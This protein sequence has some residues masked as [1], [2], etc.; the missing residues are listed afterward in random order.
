MIGELISAVGKYFGGEADRRSQ[1][2]IN[3]QM[4]ADKEQDRALQR[5]FAQHG[6]RWRV[7]DA[8]AAGLHPIYALGGS[9]ATYTPSAISLGSSKSALGEM[10]QDIGRAINSTRTSGEREDAFMQAMKVNTLRKSE[11]EN[12]LL[13]AQVAKLRASTNPPMP[14]GVTPGPVPEAK[15][16]EDR[17][18]LRIGGDEIH[19]DPRSTNAE[20]FEKRYGEL[21][22]FV[23]G[24]ALLW[25]DYVNTMGGA[26]ERAAANEYHRPRRGFSYLWD[27]FLHRKYREGR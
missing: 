23:Y 21:S 3:R 17:P 10:G 4:L 26:Q 24:P 5:E 22:D 9:G 11:L 18:R 15:K 12:D 7:E 16:F 20:D 14:T 19:T 13:S 8:K 1:E 25:Q 2:H 27:D 6:V